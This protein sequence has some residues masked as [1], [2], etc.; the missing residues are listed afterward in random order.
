MRTQPAPAAGT[1]QPLSRRLRPTALGRTAA[2]R[3]ALVGGL[4]AVLTLSGCAFGPPSGSES[5][6][7]PKLP[8]PS[9][10]PSDD[11]GGGT[12]VQVI[13]KH[14]AVP[15]G[16]AFLPDHT[17]LIT[18]RDKRQIFTLGINGGTPKLVQTISQVVPSGEGGL[19]GIAVSPHYDTDKTIFIYYTTKTDNR[20]AKL[21]LG[22]TPTPIVTGIPRSSTQDGGALAFGPDGYLYAGTGDATSPST[23]QSTSSLGGK[24]LRMTESGKPAPGNPFGNLVYAYGFRN[25]Q[26]LAW[27]EQKRL[28]AT[29]FGQDKFDEINVVTSGANYGWPQVEGTGH[30]SRYSNPLETFTPSEASCSGAAISGTILV[31]GCL[32]GER[33][34]L[35]Q[36]DGKGGALGAPQPTLKGQYGRLRAVVRAPDGTL[37]VS[38]SNRDGR[39]HPIADD[40]RILRIVI[41]GGDAVDKS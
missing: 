35:T 39:G 9:T 19:L 23:A 13:A 8:S 14:M 7:P 5:G 29:D 16:I 15:W 24:I 32:A 18:E 4:L 31:T 34:W 17:A 21:T 3:T 22:G 40:D 25:V 37:W 30:D 28:Y 2:G 6:T 38:T 27:D 26:G 12:T 36:L 10:S 11:S 33:L 41:S 1:G 20:I